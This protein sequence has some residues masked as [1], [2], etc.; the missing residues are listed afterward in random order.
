M[1]RPMKRALREPL[2]HFVLL[3]AALFALHALMT[4]E[5]A[6]MAEARTVDVSDGFVEAL[7][8]RHRQ[9][10]GAEP[11][12][13]ELESLVSA[14]VREEA[15]VREARQAGLDRGDP[16]VRRRLV[17]KIEFLIAAS[18]EVP[19][20]TDAEL[21]AEVEAHPERY[22]RPDR[23]SFEHVF[24]A[25]D[26]RGERA[27]ADAT[28]VL[29]ALRA[30]DG[31]E[32][33]RRGDPF[34]LGHAHRRKTG[35]EIARGFGPAFAEALVALPD[36]QWSDPI[37]SAYGLHLVRVTAREP[38]GMP[39]LDSIRARVLHDVT[40]A[41]REELTERAIGDLVATYEVR[42]GP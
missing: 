30:A 1:I 3:G 29:A 19:A 39:P 2:L 8:R 33:H 36:G 17:Q 6:A 10:T 15:L 23:T 32:A 5:P 14:H 31:G 42:R 38:G 11:T 24:F 7:R 40:E 34:L 37:E 18:V 12:A 41:R 9:R 26:R 13:D 22:R 27:A 20:P 16:I 28:A 21:G 35:S 25:R 4:P